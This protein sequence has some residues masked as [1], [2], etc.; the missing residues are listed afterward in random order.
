MS[1]VRFFGILALLPAAFNVAPTSAHAVAL[2]P[3][4]TGDGV[5]RSIAMPASDRDIPGK[6]VPGCCT[7]ACHTGERKR[8]KRCC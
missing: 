8:A 6:Q 5:S 4:C 7:K 1:W 2:V 3:I